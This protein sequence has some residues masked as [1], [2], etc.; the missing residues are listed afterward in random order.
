MPEILDLTRGIRIVQTILCNYKNE[1]H[2]R[3]R[4]I[5]S[6]KAN[7]FQRVWCSNSWWIIIKITWF[8]RTKTSKILRMLYRPL[9]ITSCLSKHL[10]ANLRE[11]LQE[12]LSRTLTSKVRNNLSLFRLYKMQLI[13][14][15]PKT[16]IILR[17]PSKI[18]KRR[19]VNSR[20]F[21]HLVV[22]VHRAL[23]SKRLLPRE[24]PSR[25][26][27]MDDLVTV[28]QSNKWRSYQNKWIRDMRSWN[29][30]KS[31]W[32]CRSS[33]LRWSKINKCLWEL[34]QVTSNK[35]LM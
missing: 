12:V 13:L 17:R 30:N 20:W 5:K 22:R 29:S 26:S 9:E 33:R 18:N 19:R 24:M 34:L 7:R 6:T 27:T 25:K 4:L 11:I 10:L 28:F 21:L 31:R 2:I 3:R 32:W 14:L 23:F 1:N 35:S 8:H 15:W 16:T